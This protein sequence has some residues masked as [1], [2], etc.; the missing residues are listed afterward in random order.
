VRLNWR[1]SGGVHRLLGWIPV[2]T[3]A[4]QWKNG[5]IYHNGHY[6]KLRDNYGLNQYTFRSTSFNEGTHGRWHF[7]VVVDVEA[8]MPAGQDRIGSDLGLTGTA[9]CSDGTKLEACRY[10]PGLENKLSIAQRA[11]NKRRVKTIHA[12]IVNRRKDALHKFIRK[13]VNRCGEIYA[14]NISSLKSVKTKMAKPVLDAG[15]DQ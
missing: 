14:G 8:E 2:N 3:A 11:K 5:Q 7:N 13:L 10:Y 1:K 9:T 15:W 12:K 4:V 6:F